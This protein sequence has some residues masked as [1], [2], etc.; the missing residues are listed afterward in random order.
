M[1]RMKRSAGLDIAE[2]HHVR[3]IEASPLSR[4]HGLAWVR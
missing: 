4:P 1:R 2:K 3:R